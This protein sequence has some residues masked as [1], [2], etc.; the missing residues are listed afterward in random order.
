MIRRG[1]PPHHHHHHCHQFVV[2]TLHLSLPPAVPRPPDCPPGLCLVGPLQ[3][4]FNLPAVNHHHSGW[5]P[6]PPTCCCCFSPASSVRT[7]CC[8]ASGIKDV[9]S[10]EPNLLIL[11]L[12]L[13]LC[14]SPN[15]GQC[16]R[17]QSCKQNHI[18]LQP[19]SDSGLIIGLEGCSFSGFETVSGYPVL[20]VL[21]KKAI[22]T[23]HSYFLQEVGI[24]PCTPGLLD[25]FQSLVRFIE[26]IFSCHRRSWAIF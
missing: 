6:D 7:H 22:F 16:A 14:F 2:H 12:F 26:A 21:K 19:I 23:T 13:F 20:A 11:T 10:V 1:T 9:P 18:I 5:T 8:A 17:G 15:T 25:I 4:Y 24:E 3:L